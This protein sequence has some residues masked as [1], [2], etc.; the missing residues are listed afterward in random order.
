[1][2]E[3]DHELTSDELDQISA[4]VVCITHPTEVPPRPSQTPAGA[5]TTECC[6]GKHYSEIIV[7]C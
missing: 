6:T 7:V 3:R 4:G 1:M 2:T 5:V